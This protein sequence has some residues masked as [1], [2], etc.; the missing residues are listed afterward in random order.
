MNAV[1]LSYKVCNRSDREFA[2]SHKDSLSVLAN[3][4]IRNPS[5]P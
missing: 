2:I 4:A 5:C 3:L 1:K